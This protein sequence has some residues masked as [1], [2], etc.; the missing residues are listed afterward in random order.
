[1]LERAWA[2][3]FSVLGIAATAAALP[4]CAGPSPDAQTASTLCAE[5]RALD[6]RIVDH[7]NA[8]V[9]GINSE[10]VDG[11]LPPIL[12]GVD[13]VAAELRA[14]DEQ[15]DAIELPDIDERTELRRQLHSGVD[16]ALAELDDQ[17]RT[18]ESGSSSV[19]DDEI[20]GVV[21][22]WFNAVEKVFSVSEP[23]IFR[24]ERIEFKQAFLD[25]PDCR[26][27]I[28]QFVND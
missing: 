7:V 14:W 3:R 24:F 4:G 9:E 19:A 6:N 26:N 28:Q 22:T 11:R 2:R 18:F 10:P 25:E 8:S 27:V 23:Q 1:M 16:E 13:D 5:L 20:P 12:D 15:I 21:S 17:R